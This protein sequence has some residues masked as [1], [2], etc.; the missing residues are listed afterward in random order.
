MLH[1]Q[2]MKHLCFFYFMILTQI[3][4]AQGW[5]SVALVKRDGTELKG[6]IK[7]RDNIAFREVKVRI[8]NVSKWMPLSDIVSGNIDGKPFIVAHLTEEEGDPFALA[9]PLEQ[10]NLYFSLF[11]EREC[12]CNN[13]YKHS[14]AYLLF[15]ENRWKV[16]RKKAFRD[17]VKNPEIIYLLKPE[18]SGKKLRFSEIPQLF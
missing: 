7:F 10:Q 15:H 2:P 17:E 3:L 6:D 14:R 11:Q 13:S 5:R 1:L 4:F 12:L 8:D 18:I 16:L 9:W